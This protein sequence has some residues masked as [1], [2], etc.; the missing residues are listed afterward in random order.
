[1]LC[2]LSLGLW[3]IRDIAFSCSLPL[4]FKNLECALPKQA[5]WRH[6]LATAIVSQRLWEDFGKKKNEQ[7]YLAGLLHDIGILVKGLLFPKIF[8]T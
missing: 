2:V 3:R 8:A 5:F 4:M 7:C 6:A 1:M